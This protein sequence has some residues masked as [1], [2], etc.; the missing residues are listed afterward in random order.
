MRAMT[1]AIPVYV[2]MV[3]LW[4]GL[5]LNIS[6]SLNEPNN[7]TPNIIPTVPDVAF[8]WL[9][10]LANTGMIVVMCFALWQLLQ[11]NKA[12]VRKQLF[13]MGAFRI[14]GLVLTL[15]FS[16]PALYGV[17]MLPLHLV[18]GNMPVSFANPRY[19]ISALCIA[20]CALLCVWRL[21][22]WW[23]S[24]KTLQLPTPTGEHAQH[25]MREH[26]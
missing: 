3:D 17:L 6:Q 8:N 9:Q 5:V 15:A 21:F 26:S 4:Y 12:V 22:G 16:L 7:N 1:A 20:Y 25:L 19:L 23:R 11:L 13:A 2:V 18:Q 10:V 14:L 24:R